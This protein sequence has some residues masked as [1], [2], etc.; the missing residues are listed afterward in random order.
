L[1]IPPTEP[2]GRWTAAFAVAFARFPH[3]FIVGFLSL[4]LAVLL[5]GLGML[6]LQAKKYFEE[7]VFLQMEVKTAVRTLSAQVGRE[8]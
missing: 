8:R 5:I 2:G 3:T 4:V 7:T 1:E 6:A